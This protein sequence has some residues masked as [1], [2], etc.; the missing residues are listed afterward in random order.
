VE[1]SAITLTKPLNP[2]AG[3][4]KVRVNVTQP[5]VNDEVQFPDAFGTPPSVYDIQADPGKA[6]V[7]IGGITRV[8]L[9]LL[10]VVAVL[11]PNVTVLAADAS[12][13]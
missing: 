11:L 13:P 10:F 6:E 2:A 8:G 4:S 9:P 1:S 5:G 3:V 12:P 7:T